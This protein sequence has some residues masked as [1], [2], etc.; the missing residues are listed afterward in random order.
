[1]NRR[2]L[3]AAVF[4]GGVLGPVFLLLALHRES[5]ASVSL[6]L[7]LEIVATAVL[8]VGFFHEYLGK[9]GWAGIAAILAGGVLLSFQGGAP[10]VVAGLLAAAACA[11]WGLD[12]NL[13]A[14]IDGLS[15]AETTF[16]KGV[17]AGSTNLLLGLALAPFDASL[18]TIAAALVVGMFS[19]G[20]SIVLYITAAQQIGAARSQAAFASAPFVGAALSFLLLKDPLG[21]PVIAAGILFGLGVI[22]SFLD[23]HEHEHKHEVSTHVHAHRHDDGHHTHE[24]AGIAP[25]T[26]H[27]HEHVHAPLTHSHR[28]LPDL[29]HRHS[30]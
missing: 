8:A 12:N 15:P 30:H 27:T 29:H 24:H 16:W 5:A 9:S 18:G 4:F 11:C 23:R 10:G 26:G 1:M 28:H 3:A 19:F 14:L 21:L 13:T 17:V 20:A 25:G 7:N 22:L 2:R 6:L